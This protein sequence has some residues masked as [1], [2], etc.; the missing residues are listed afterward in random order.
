MIVLTHRIAGISYRSELDVLVPH[1]QRDPFERF[2]INNIKPDVLQRVRQFDPESYTLPRLDTKERECIVRS[3]GFPQ[4]WVEHPVWGSPDIRAVLQRCLDRPE[5]AQIEL[6]W[7]RVIIRNFYRSEFDL[8]YPPEKRKGF[9]DP[10]FVASFRNYLATFLPNFSAVL[11]HAS[12]VIRNNVAAVFLSPDEGGKTSVVKLSTGAPILNDDH[13]VLRRNSN[14]VMAH[15]SP[16]GPITSGPQKKAGLG[17]LF[18]LEK[19]SGFDLIPVKA[20]D[21]LQFIWNESMFRW[22][23]LPKN[24]RKRAFEILYDA[25]HQ[26]P[27]YRMRFSKYYVDWDAIDAAME[28][29]GTSRR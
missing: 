9:A 26:V 6:A 21:I 28:G 4:R 7:N 15:S 24:L 29:N 11:I 3:V 10:F 27:V 16:L 5:L 22:H 17:G 20:S 12:G 23:M 2:R 25:C 18:L 13:I 19:S 1:I 8:F 14:A